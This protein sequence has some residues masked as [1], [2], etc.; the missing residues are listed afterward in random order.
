[1]QNNNGQNMN[2]EN[3]NQ[4][5]WEEKLNTTLGIVG[6]NAK[7][8]ISDVAQ[9]FKPAPPPP[10]MLYCSYCNSL[11]PPYKTICIKCGAGKKNAYNQ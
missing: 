9:M 1:M 7:S 10:P 3:Q 8:F 11:L 2:Q 4:Q 5:G 6:N